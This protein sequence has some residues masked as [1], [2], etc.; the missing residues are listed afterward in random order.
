MCPM[1]LDFSFW[2]PPSSSRNTLPRCVVF[3][4][5]RGSLLYPR[6]I[7]ALWILL[8]TYCLPCILM[9]IGITSIL[10]VRMIL[11]LS[12]G[13]FFIRPL[14]LSTGGQHPSSTNAQIY[15]SSTRFENVDELSFELA[16][17]GDKF[18]I[19]AYNL[20]DD[21][22]QATISIVYWKSGQM[23]KVPFFSLQPGNYIDSILFFR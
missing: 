16:V 15:I 19:F 7:S 23:Y 1:A 12:C 14:S 21:D 13:R 17:A 3:P 11:K 18:T 20:D 9:A 22:E 6:L 2:I 10:T 8:K 4:A 5:V